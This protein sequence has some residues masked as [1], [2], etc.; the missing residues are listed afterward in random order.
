MLPTLVSRGV[1][2][3]WRAR[4]GP[5]A[6]FWKGR[7]NSFQLQ[8]PSHSSPPTPATISYPTI[9]LQNPPTLPQPLNPVPSFHKM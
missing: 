6:R 5:G 3:T 1:Q 4:G 7:A 9:H 8:P 2:L